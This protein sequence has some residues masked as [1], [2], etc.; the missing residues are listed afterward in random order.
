MINATAGILTLNS[1]RTIYKCLNSVKKFKEILIIDGGSTDSTLN[2]AKKFKCKILQQ[3]KNFQFKDKRIKDFASLR[4]QILKNAKYQL[5]L[6]IDSDEVLNEKNLNFIDFLSKSNNFKKNYYTYLIPRIPSYKNICYP[7][8][9]LFPEYQPRIFNKF[10][11]SRFVKHV[12]ETPLP[13]NKK[14][15]SCKID[16]I[17]LKF[18]L[19]F[20]EKKYKYYL[21]IEKIMLKKN[22][23][24]SLQ[25]IFFRFLVNLKKFYKFLIYNKSN[26]MIKKYER[27]LIT[28]NIKYSLKLFF[29]KF[30]KFK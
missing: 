26:P 20:S 22:F 9:S 15:K 17:S 11:V 13:K 7:N 30:S 25:F 2:F 12:H 16:K 8:S 29:Y 19:S 5:V 28:N 4:N 10:N 23:L 1:S 3:N 27:F 14:I 24:R 18:K 6:M 21:S